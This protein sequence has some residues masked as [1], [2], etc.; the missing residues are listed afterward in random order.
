MNLCTFV[1][2]RLI[3]FSPSI[4]SRICLN[5]PK[6][7]SRCSLSSPRLTQTMTGTCSCT[8]C[9]EGLVRGLAQRPEI[10]GCSSYFHTG[11]PDVPM[12][13]AHPPVYYKSSVL[14]C[15]SWQ[16]KQNLHMFSADAFV[17]WI[18][19]VWGCLKSWL[20]NTQLQKAER[21]WISVVFAP[22][23]FNPVFHKV[24]LFLKKIF[25]NRKHSNSQ[26]ETYSSTSPLFSWSLEM[27][28]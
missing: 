2:E 21:A 22:K 23:Y 26:L 5:A 25:F 3:F 24:G 15:A 16:G 18:F 8:Q 9:A 11:L 27:A 28:Y 4:V 20:Q 6:N 1:E 12:T 14:C 13:C 17:L 7:N 19:L 10:L